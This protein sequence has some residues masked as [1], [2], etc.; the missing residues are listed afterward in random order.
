MPKAN[1]VHDMN[2][3]K[4]SVKVTKQSSSRFESGQL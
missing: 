2:V 1:N 3:E 4:A